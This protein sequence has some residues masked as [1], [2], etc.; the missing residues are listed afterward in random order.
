M[1]YRTA[2]ACALVLLLAVS[3]RVAADRG[4]LVNGAELFN[5][6]SVPPS[7]FRSV[8]DH[9]PSFFEYQKLVLYHPKF[10]YYTTGQV[11]FL[12]DF[13]TFPTLLAP[14]FG[15][16]VAEQTFRMWAGMRQ[17]QTLATDDP[18]VIAE[19][20]G[21][22]GILAE[23]IL[24]YVSH[25]A[26]VS[27]DGRWR[28]FHRQLRYLGFDLS[29]ALLR[30]QRTRTARFGAQF[31]ARIGDATAMSA[32]FGAG[33]VTGV[34][35]SNE[36]LDTF[37][38]H[39]VIVNAT[40]EAEVCYVAAALSRRNWSR[41]EK[42]IPDSVRQLLI[43]E[44]AIV[45][46]ASLVRRNGPLW[47]TSTSLAAFLDAVAALPTRESDVRLLDFHEIYLPVS[48]VPAIAEHMARYRSQYA[49]AVARR[50]QSYITYVNLGIPAFIHGAADALKS[51]YVMTIDYGGGWGEMLSL[52]P[53]PHLRVYGPNTAPPVPAVPP[54][55][56]GD[57]PPQLLA[58]VRN[59]RASANPY[60][61]PT[62]NDITTDVNFGVLSDEGR[63]R[64]LQPVYFGPQRAL[65]FGTG[66]SLDTPRSIHTPAERLDYAFWVRDFESNDSF[67]VLVQQK[68]RTDQTYRGLSPE[69]APLQ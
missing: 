5:E 50:G 42:R 69:T 19:F 40:G 43:T 48:F 67:K 47:L 1:R 8:A 11:N 30:Q 55:S 51:G 28:E 64:G 15:H 3:A 35:L 66:V 20:G 62:L 16:M 2:F 57:P 21:G 7:A 49:A 29:E 13:R 18:F 12:A 60:S 45:E 24:D 32:L 61:S 36:L 34:I 65:R 22:N 23:S 25:Q 26:S 54:P 17:A 10:G 46:E 14:Y 58:E 44:S 4:R 52:A 63:P 38:V 59:Q 68:E 56:S 39:K 53:R 6:V 41:V 9:F 31:D 37:P 27:D 33:S